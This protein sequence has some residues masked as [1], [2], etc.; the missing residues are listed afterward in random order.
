M[1]QG[2]RPTVCSIVLHTDKQTEGQQVEVQTDQS[3]IIWRPS[4]LLLREIDHLKEENEV[5][6]VH[7]S[8]EFKKLQK[9]SKLLNS[10]TGVAD[11]FR[12]GVVELFKNS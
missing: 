3:T 7:L 1:P 5:M 6:R 2:H 8:N 9:E 11:F 10:F 12:H 4:S